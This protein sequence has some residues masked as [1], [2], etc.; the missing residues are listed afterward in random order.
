MAAAGCD[1]CLSFTEEQ[2]GGRQ[3]HI[4]FRCGQLGPQRQNRDSPAGLVMKRVDVRAPLAE[5]E[6]PYR[7]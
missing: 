4:V 2:L 5:P 7:M 1:P 6:M 3:V